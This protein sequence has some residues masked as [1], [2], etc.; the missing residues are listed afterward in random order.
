M[1][2]RRPATYKVVLRRLPVKMSRSG[3]E[4]TARVLAGAALFATRGG[5]QPHR[6]SVHHHAVQGGHLVP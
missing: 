4:L 2:A 6:A 3:A 1:F 5:R